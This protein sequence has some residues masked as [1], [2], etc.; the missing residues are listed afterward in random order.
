MSSGGP[1]KESA[2]HLAARVRDGEKCAEML[3]KSGGDPNLQ[4]TDGQTPLML[5]AHHGNSRVMK[6]LIE[7]GADPVVRAKVRKT[8]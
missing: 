1:A 6:L 5:A 3:L 7:Y 2:L 4:K 8:N